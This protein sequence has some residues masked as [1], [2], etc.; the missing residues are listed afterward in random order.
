MDGKLLLNVL[1]IKT[2]NVPAVLYCNIYGEDRC[3]KKRN[4]A[5][6]QKNCPAALY[7]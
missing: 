5:A 7:S 3:E 4:K 6:E 1:F 2:I